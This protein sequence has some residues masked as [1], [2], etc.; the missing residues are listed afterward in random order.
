MIKETLKLR[1]EENHKSFL[2]YI[3]SLPDE[4]FVKSKF[5]KWTAGQQLEHIYLS[6]KPVRQA[7]SLPGFILSVLWGKANRKSRNF[8]ELVTRYLDKLSNGGKAP[9]RFIPAKAGLEKRLKLTSLLAKEILKLNSKIDKFSESELDEFVIPHPLLGKL[10]V[11]EML[12][13]TIYHVEHHQKAVR[14]IC[15]P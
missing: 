11:R 2:N 1:L 13:F 10:T 14:E 15:E 9:G 4:M 8:D 7:L 12:Y 5:E 3:N 6:V